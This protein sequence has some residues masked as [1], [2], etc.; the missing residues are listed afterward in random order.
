MEFRDNVRGACHSS[1]MQCSFMEMMSKDTNCVHRDEQN[2]SLA[3]SSFIPLVSWPDIQP[4]D[5][6]IIG[7][8]DTQGNQLIR[9]VWFGTADNAQQQLIRQGVWFGRADNSQQQLIREVWFGR[10]DNAQQQLIRDF[11]LAE[12]T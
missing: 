12:Q 9:G 4:A 7:G 11:G 6:A 1:A 3:D 10:V 2:N 8:T 5:N